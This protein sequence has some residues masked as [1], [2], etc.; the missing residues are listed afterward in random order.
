MN[1]PTFEP[2]MEHVIQTTELIVAKCRKHNLSV[3]HLQLQGLLYFVQ[4]WSKVLLGEF[5]FHPGFEAWDCGTIN[6]WIDGEFNC[7]G[8]DPVTLKVNFQPAQDTLIRA[9]LQAYGHYS[10][11]DLMALIKQESPWQN[12]WQAGCKMPIPDQDIERAFSDPAIFTRTDA[13]GVRIHAH[14]FDLYRQI[15]HGMKPW[16]GAPA[17]ASAD[18]IAELEAA[19][20]A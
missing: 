1:A 5:R 7:F 16:E 13:R 19:I 12:H 9:V 18:E 2:T 20:A 3:N 14:F 8:D 17:P 4:G 11:A 15:K 10:A 6:P